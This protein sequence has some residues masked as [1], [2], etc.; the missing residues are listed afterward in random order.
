MPAETTEKQAKP[1]S[2]RHERFCEGVASGM[3]G[4]EAYVYAGYKVSPSVASVSAYHLLRNPKVEARIAE[5]RIPESTALAMSKDRK[6][7]MLMEIAEN[8]E[9][10]MQDR[11]RAIEIDA[12]LAGHFAAEEM[13]VEVGSRPIDA[14]EKRAAGMV[15][16]LD[17]FSR[18]SSAS[19]SPK[20]STP[21]QSAMDERTEEYFAE[22]G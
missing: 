2:V 8:G 5:L 21:A 17:A 11:L 22:E 1:L 20:R 15:S 13:V 10:K 3:N 6:R 18:R 19:P 16:M 9:N 4:A 12:K 7:E 14:I